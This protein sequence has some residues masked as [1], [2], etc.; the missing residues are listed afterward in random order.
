VMVLQDA[1]SLAAS[2]KFQ[3]ICEIKSKFENK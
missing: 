3:Y 1:V 2:F